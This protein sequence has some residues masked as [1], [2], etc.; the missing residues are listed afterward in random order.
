M[1]LDVRG[2]LDLPTLLVKVKNYMWI[3]SGSVWYM[4]FRRAGKQSNVDSD[5]ETERFLE[6]CQCGLIKSDLHGHA[7]EIVLT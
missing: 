3:G 6:P 7:S 5:V 2:N 4:T 1:T